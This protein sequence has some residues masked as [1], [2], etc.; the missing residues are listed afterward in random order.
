MSTTPQR[1][2]S[3]AS[4]PTPIRSGIRL[5]KNPTDALDPR[6]RRVHGTHMGF[7]ATSQAGHEGYGR[8]WPEILK[9]DAAV[10]ARALRCSAANRGT[11][12]DYFS[13]FA[14]FSAVGFAGSRGAHT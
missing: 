5:L 11:R 6:R 9:M 12:R 13:F 4:A 1:G 7:D 2:C 8:E 3:S 10:K 14:S